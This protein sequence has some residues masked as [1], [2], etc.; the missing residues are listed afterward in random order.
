MRSFFAL[1]AG[2][3]P[4]QNFRAQ[5]VGPLLTPQDLWEEARKAPPSLLFRVRSESDPG[6]PLAAGDR[7][8]S[9]IGVVDAHTRWRVAFAMTRAMLNSVR[10]P[11]LRGVLA[12]AMQFV[13]SQHPSNIS[14]DQRGEIIGSI[15]KAAQ[16][17]DPPPNGFEQRIAGGV[18][19]LVQADNDFEA[20]QYVPF[21]EVLCPFHQEQERQPYQERMATVETL[22][23]SYLITAALE[24]LSER[25]PPWLYSQMPA[26]ELG[27]DGRREED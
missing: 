4:P 11:Q 22:S 16:E 12:Q 15:Y 6:A 1:H 21:V 27:G 18:A 26:L 25:A 19:R 23:G 13:S 20:A 14:Q 2:V 3:V 10:H 5:A 17:G 9:C 7:L 24:R 8:E